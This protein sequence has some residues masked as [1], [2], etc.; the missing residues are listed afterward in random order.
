[1]KKEERS[2]AARALHRFEKTVKRQTM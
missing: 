2:S 1:M